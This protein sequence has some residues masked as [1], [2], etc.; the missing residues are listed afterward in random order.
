MDNSL[1]NRIQKLLETEQMSPAAFA[2]AIQVNPS[3][4]SHILNDRNKPSTDILTKILTYF[5][6]L[7]SEWLIMGLGNMYK[8]DKQTD[9]SSFASSLF[10]NP[11]SEIQQNVTQVAE[12][13]AL[14]SSQSLS[15]PIKP[16]QT[17]QVPSTIIEKE[18]IKEV[19]IKAPERKVQKIIIYYSDNTFDEMTPNTSH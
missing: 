13:S 4:I 9:S 12:P 17:A 14:F 1:R 19:L 8:S 7:N 3:A 11:S 6:T 16:E 10:D 15:E 5:R 18:I 2:K